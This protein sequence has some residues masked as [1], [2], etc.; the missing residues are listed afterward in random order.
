MAVATATAQRLDDPASSGNVNVWH[1]EHYSLNLALH[2]EKRRAFGHVDIRIRRLPFVTAP[3]AGTALVLDSHTLEVASVTLA[4]AACAFEVKPFA[5]FGSAL[6]IDL[7]AAGSAVTAGDALIVRVHYATAESSPAL[8]WLAPEQT[9]DKKHPFL[10]SQGQAVLN[11]SL[12]PCQDTPGRRAS[13]E[14]VMLVPKPYVIVMSGQQEISEAEAAPVSAPLLPTSPEVLALY[15]PHLGITSATLAESDAPAAGEHGAAFPHL[16][17]PAYR[18]FRA[19]M[20]DTVP[21]YLFA[22]AAGDLRCKRIGGRTRVW[23]EESLIDRCVWEF[24]HRDV[25]E[26]YLSV[27]EKLF[28]EYRWGSYRCAACGAVCETRG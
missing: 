6:H 2:F 12:F 28:G 20:P 24:G 22:L 9:A 8:S 18:A 21:M 17:A 3:E 5:A 14:A 7:G 1:A 13:W 15:P 10:F 23:S 4:G 11:R 16:P 27:A 25:T 19:R 26:N